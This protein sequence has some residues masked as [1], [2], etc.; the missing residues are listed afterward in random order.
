MRPKT[1]IIVLTRNRS[2]LLQKCLEKL[3]PQL[4]GNDAIIIVNNGST[5]TETKKIKQV[6]NHLKN[7]N[8]QLVWGDKKGNIPKGRNKGIVS[9]SKK[10]Q[11]IA[12]L[13]DDCLPNKNWSKNIRK[14]HQA[15]HE[16]QV[17]Q[18]KVISIPK[19]NLYARITGIT[20][21][22][23]LRSNLLNKNLLATFDSKNVSFKVKVFRSGLSFNEKFGRSSD[24]ELGLRLRKKGFKIGYSPKIKTYHRER[25]T[26]I[27]FLKQHINIAKGERGVELVGLFPSRYKYHFFLFRRLAWQLFKERKFLSLS[28]F[29]LLIPLILILRTAVFLSRPLQYKS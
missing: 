3:V 21:Q 15:Y 2:F 10:S 18:G 26:L 11:I 20:Y 28:L 12:F 14:E 29:L 4:R 8:L 27:P 9:V 6:I 24:I 5:L 1:S 13:D 19:N 23:W 25:T 17:I 16:W 22:N 7:K